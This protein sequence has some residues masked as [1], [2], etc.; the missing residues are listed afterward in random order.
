MAHAS[1]SSGRCWAQVKLDPGA[2]ITP[3]NPSL[4]ISGSTFLL[5][6][7]SIRWACSNQASQGARRT[8]SLFQ[9]QQDPSILGAQCSSC[10]LT[11]PSGRGLGCL[12]R[13]W[14]LGLP[15]SPRTGALPGSRRY[16]AG[17]FQGASRR[18]EEVVALRAGKVL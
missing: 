2:Q 6:H 15:S 8:P 7:L 16:Q 10:S 4:S 12:S 11:H 1:K 18:F 14:V 13:M 9:M 5:G 17:V 3:E